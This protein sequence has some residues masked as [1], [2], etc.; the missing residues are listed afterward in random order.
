MVLLLLLLLRGWR[1]GE[2]DV[3]FSIL[4]GRDCGYGTVEICDRHAEKIL[5]YIVCASTSSST[6]CSSSSYS[7]SSDVDPPNGDVK[8]LGSDGSLCGGSG[9][10]E[11]EFDVA[12]EAGLGRGFRLP[13]SGMLLGLLRR[14]VIF[15]FGLGP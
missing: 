15:R 7:S 2:F 14:M 4:R 5:V 8:A 6:S 1:A 11:L 9:R 12:G 13:S 3:L 10:C